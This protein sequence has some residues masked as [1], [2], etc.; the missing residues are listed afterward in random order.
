MDDSQRLPCRLDRGNALRARDGMRKRSDGARSDPSQDS[1]VE[2][3]LRRL[4]REEVER[5]STEFTVRWR[6]RTYLTVAQAAA[7]VD[8]HFETITQALRRGELHGFQRMKGARWLVQDDC[9]IAWV[10]GEACGHRS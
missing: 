5:V 2:V 6:E 4:V 7:L 3:L 10:T 8:Q 1:D 9:L